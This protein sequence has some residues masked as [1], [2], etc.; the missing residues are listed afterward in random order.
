MIKLKDFLKVVPP[1]TTIEITYH[2]KNKPLVKEIGT[3]E[4]IKYRSQY[5]VKEVDTFLSILTISVIERRKNDF[6]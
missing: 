2:R 3:A 4:D 6:R 1:N 5:Y